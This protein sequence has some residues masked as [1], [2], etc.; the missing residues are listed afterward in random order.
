MVSYLIRL[1]VFSGQRRRS[2][3]KLRSYQVHRGYKPLPQPKWPFLGYFCVVSIQVAE[4]SGGTIGRWVGWETG[5]AES[6]PEPD[7]GDR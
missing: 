4:R 2:G 1:A 3:E 7:T 6:S 5:P